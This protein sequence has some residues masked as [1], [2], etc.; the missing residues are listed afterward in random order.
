VTEVRPKV[1]IGSSVEGL[2]VAEALYA[3]LSRNCQVTVWTQD[4]FRPSRIA[5]NELIRNAEEHEFAILIFTPDDKLIKRSRSVAVPR[6]NVIFELGLF[7]GKLGLERAFFVYCEDDDIEVPTDLA[8]VTPVTYKKAETNKLRSA[9]GPAALSIR[10]AI[11]SVTQASITSLPSSPRAIDAAIEVMPK[12]RQEWSKADD[13]FLAGFPYSWQYVETAV[14]AWLF[15]HHT[16]MI[17]VY[18]KPE[19]VE[20]QPTLLV[21]NVR[22]NPDFLVRHADGTTTIAEVKS[23]L[24]AQ[25]FADLEA[26]VLQVIAYTNVLDLGPLD[27]VLI[28][29]VQAGNS[30]VLGGID[31]SNRAAGLLPSH[32]DMVLGHMTGDAS[33]VSNIQFSGRARDK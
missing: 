17:H 21:N 15:R 19:T 26:E 28:V 4:S 16:D 24:K 8:G 10:E 3:E 18:A 29:L 32:V 5:I 7:I 11:G 25:T 6:D 1:F 22:L 12:S 31:D 2:D 30:S 9:V 23:L 20:Q 33:F 14:I 27:R 13:R